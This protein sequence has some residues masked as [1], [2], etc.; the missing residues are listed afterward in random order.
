M[1][2]TY[3]ATIMR[4]FFFFAF[5]TSSSFS[6]DLKQA[7]TIFGKLLQTSCTLCRL[8]EKSAQVYRECPVDHWSKKRETTVEQKS[9]LAIEYTDSYLNTAMQH[10][11]NIYCSYDVNMVTKFVRALH[12]IN[13]FFMAYTEEYFSS[14]IY[15]RS[16]IVN[17]QEY[18]QRLLDMYQ[19]DTHALLSDI[20]GFGRQLKLYL[21][22]CKSVVKLNKYIRIAHTVAFYFESVKKSNPAFWQQKPHHE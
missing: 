15:P 1:V 14:V 6:P 17:R 13:N 19:H 20:M 22:S 4:G 7:F 18:F 10:L 5:K 2:T 9:A 16:I 21:G 8:G 12:F 3:Y 11:V